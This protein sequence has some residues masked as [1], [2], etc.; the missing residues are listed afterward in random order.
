MN[1]KEAKK[2]KRNGIL[3]RSDLSTESHT[4]TPQNECGGCD[5]YIVIYLI[6]RKEMDNGQNVDDVAYQLQIDWFLYFVF[7][8][9]RFGLESGIWRIER[10]RE[11]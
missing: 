10:E 5:S 8:L 3:K 4:H 2:Y 11:I 6:K 7:L 1:E 9:F